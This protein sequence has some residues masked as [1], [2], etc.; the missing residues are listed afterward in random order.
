MS[1]RFDHCCGLKIGHE[2]IVLEITAKA[3]RGD[4]L[5]RGRKKAGFQPNSDVMGVEGVR[6]ADE[7]DPEPQVYLSVSVPKFPSYFVANGVRGMK[8][9]L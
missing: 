4:Q 5:A 9:G 3:A 2:F 1:Q 8:R 7:F 6:M